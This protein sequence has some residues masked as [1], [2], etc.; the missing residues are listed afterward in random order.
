VKTAVRKFRAEFED[1]LRGGK[2]STA[3]PALVGAH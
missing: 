1:Y 3:A 2:K